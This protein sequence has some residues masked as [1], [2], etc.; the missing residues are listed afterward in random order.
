MES[1]KKFVFAS[2]LIKDLKLSTIFK[3]ANFDTKIDSS[4]INRPGLQLSGFLDN[5]Q[6]K[7]VQIMGQTEYLYFKSLNI[8]QRKNA[9]DKLMSF[10]IPIL[11]ISTKQDVLPEIL[12]SAK[13]NSRIVA[14][15]RESSTKTLSR[16]SYYLNERLAPEVTI[17][18]VLVDV[19]GVGI[20][21]T[22][23]SGVGKSEAALELIKRNHRLVA[24]DAVRIIKLDE[25]TLQG[26]SLETI[27]HF[28]EIRGLGIIDIK[29]LYGIG[30]VKNSKK[31]D[32][33]VELETWQQGKYYDRLGLDQDYTQ[34][35]NTKVEKLT[36]PV[37]PG[38]NI[39]IILEL[40]ARNHRLKA[41]GYNSAV[42]FNE[43]L[44]HSL[45]KKRNENKLN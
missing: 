7:R 24:D 27:E 4:D 35:L 5:F 36:I 9:M 44:I 1:D 30:A 19:D 15:S 11:V 6:Y 40:A 38:R 21:I 26:K 8:E 29:T 25:E 32:M 22:G 39:G 23:E 45:E 28:M 43:K 34:I 33:I 31:I 17:H 41:M 37:R 13:V 14:G 3:P 20:L 10:D 18:G 12:D 2:Q 16:I 42:E